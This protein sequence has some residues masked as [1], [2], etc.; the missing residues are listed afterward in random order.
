MALYK[1]ILVLLIIMKKRQDQSY[2]DHYMFI[3]YVHFFSKKNKQYD[4]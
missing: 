2:K 3:C 4:K 1:D